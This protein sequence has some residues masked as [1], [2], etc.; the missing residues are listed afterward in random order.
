M[1]HHWR[2]VVLRHYD[3]FWAPYKNREDPKD[4]MDFIIRAN[5]LGS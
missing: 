5:C 4:K 3:N 1:A 2:H